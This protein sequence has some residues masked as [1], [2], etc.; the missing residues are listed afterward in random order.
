MPHVNYSVR[1]KGA[2]CCSPQARTVPFPSQAG[3]KLLNR[4]VAALDRKGEV[5][6]VLAEDEFDDLLLYADKLPG[7]GEALQGVLD[8]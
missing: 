1:P 3:R 4:W 5:L 7:L 6:G 2:L 8:R